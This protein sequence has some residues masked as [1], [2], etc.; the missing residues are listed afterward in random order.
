VAAKSYKGVADA[1]SITRPGDPGC[2]KRDLY[3]QLHPEADF[4]EVKAQILADPYFSH[5]DVRVYQV[6]SVA[7]LVDT[8]HRI[9]VFRKGGS[10]GV[11]NQL[12]TFETTFHNPASTAQVLVSAARAAKRL[13]PGAHT[14]LEIPLAA[15]LQEDALPAMRRLV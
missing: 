6:D 11:D 2:H 14:M 1:L 3:L 7:P 12:L 13:P 9:H 5:D 8:G 4:A 10:S 15:F